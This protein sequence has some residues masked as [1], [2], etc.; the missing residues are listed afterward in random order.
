M[1]NEPVRP[2]VMA[3]LTSQDG[4]VHVGGI[5]R[6]AQ[7]SANSARTV[8]RELEQAGR[9]EVRPTGDMPGPTG[10][11]YRLRPADPARHAPRGVAMTQEEKKVS[12]QLGGLYK[13]TVVFYTGRPAT[14]TDVAGL[15]RALRRED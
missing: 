8:L 3:F 7:V 10:A 1:T 4:F 9:L 13:T 12:E 2:R 5:A 14:A 11:G 15:I 6:G